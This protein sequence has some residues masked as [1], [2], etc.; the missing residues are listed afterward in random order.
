MD[1]H[2]N[3]KCVI[4]FQ[5]TRVDL[6]GSVGCH[7]LELHVVIEFIRIGPDAVFLTDVDVEREI[8][9]QNILPIRASEIGLEIEPL[10]SHIF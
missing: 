2:R 10:C 1:I 8:G 7:V 9:S 5:H 3:Y 6:E 4:T